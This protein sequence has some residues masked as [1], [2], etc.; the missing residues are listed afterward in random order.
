MIELT[1]QYVQFIGSTHALS[2]YYVP[3]SVANAGRTA[4][5]MIEKSQVL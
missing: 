3:A 2:T 5:N 4:E 1:G